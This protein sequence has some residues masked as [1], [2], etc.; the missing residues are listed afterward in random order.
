[1]R[2]KIKRILKKLRRRRRGFSLLELLIT[3]GIF[4]ILLVMTTSILML[5]LTAARKIRA[6]SYAREES[7]FMLNILK[8][9]IRNANSI[10]CPTGEEYGSCSA[11]A[12]VRLENF[13]INLTKSDGIGTDY[14]IWQRVGDRVFRWR[15]NT[16]G[17]KSYVTPSDIKFATSDGFG[18]FIKCRGENCLV[19]MNTKFWTQGMP[20]DPDD[21]STWQWM[22]KEVVV[23]TR[24]FEF[25]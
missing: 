21:E 25:D 22:S 18:V 6:R 19:N 24:N 12:G 4:G 20:G 9:D 15:G 3:L 23:S 17:V 7:A 10:E 1:V 13:R 2:N 14:F 11:F 5:N 8:K 16:T